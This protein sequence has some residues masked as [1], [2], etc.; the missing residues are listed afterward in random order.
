MQGDVTHRIVA[1]LSF[2]SHQ[3]GD[4]REGTYLRAQRLARN[5]RSPTVR[6]RGRENKARQRPAS[7]GFLLGMRGPRT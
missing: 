7:P 4:L 2:L 3:T 6:S 1:G 5:G